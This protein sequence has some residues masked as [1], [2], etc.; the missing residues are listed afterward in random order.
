M[1]DFTLLGKGWSY[2]AVGNVGGTQGYA[3]RELCGVG[4]HQFNSFLRAA[5]SIL[6]P[7]PGGR[8][9]VF[10]RAPA[11]SVPAPFL[12]CDFTEG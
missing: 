7:R 10:R 3:G 12:D 5:N 2:F 8:R 1:A 9:R 11:D 6:Q 4:I